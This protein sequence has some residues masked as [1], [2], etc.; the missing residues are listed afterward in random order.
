MHVLLTGATGF[1][2]S[3]ITDSLVSG[4]NEITAILRKQSN[5]LSEVVT[6]F[7][8]DLEDLTDLA[9]ETFSTVDCVIHSAAR[10]HLMVKNSHDSLYEYRKI[11]RDATLDLAKL[12]S[13][14]GVKRFVYLSSIKVNGEL[15]HLGKLFKPDDNFYSNDAYGTSKYEAELGLLKLAKDSGM[16]VVIIRPP[17]VY[18]PN[19]RANFANMIGWVK[20]GIPLPFGMIENK[21][22]LIALDNLVNFVLLCSDRKRSPNAANQVFLI[23]DGEDVSTTTLLKRVARAYGVKSHLFP[24]PV[25]VMRLFAKLLGRNEIADRLFG[26]LQVD[27]SKARELLG[28]KPVVTMDEQLRKMANAQSKEKNL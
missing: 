28:W 7:I 21:R 4:Q 16:E 14:N 22:S 5:N 26:D 6:Q 1:V 8:C 17:L 27:S 11:N 3:A 12:A 9:E 20:K 24:V 18:G 15:T 23:S 2:G 25:L 13:E 19:V 10:V